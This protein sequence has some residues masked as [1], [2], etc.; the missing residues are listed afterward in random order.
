MLFV[1][2]YF[3]IAALFVESWVVFRRMRGKMH[4]YIF[5]SC[6]ATLV[7]N[8]GYL[9]QMR[10]V[11]EEAY[12]NALEVAYLGKVWIPYSL[13]LFAMAL[14]RIRV[15][16]PA[17]ITLSVVHVVTFFLLLT[18]EYHE[19][20]YKDI[21][22]V[23]TGLFPQLAHGSGPWHV[24]YDML[25]AFY[26][27][28][29]LIQMFR[30]WLREKDPT[31]KGCLFMVFL[32]FVSDSGSFLLYKLMKSWSYDVTTLGYTVAALFMYVAIFRYDLLDTVELAREFVIDELSEG[33]IAV[34]AQGTVG[35]YN[36]PA[37]A[38]FPS[39]ETD[40]QGVVETLRGAIERREPLRFGER[41]Y[42]PEENLLSR[43][44]G[45]AGTIYVLADNTEH[46]R[47][48]ER[49]EEQTRRADSAS[50]A[51]SAFLANM[52]HEIRTPINA[53]LGM[54]EMILRESA[55]P[56]ILTYAEDIRSAGKTLLS[57][58][59][60]VLDLSKI[61]EGRMEILPAPY[62]LGSLVND[63]INMTRPRAEDKGLRFAVKV[64]AAIPGRLVG[65]EVR[66]RQCALNVLTNA[67]K[68]T[69][70]GS[71]TMELGYERT[72]EDAVT[73]RFSVS[74]TGIG[75]K[76]ED[77]ERLFA[78]FAR[79]EELRNRNI[80]GAGLGMSITKQLLS[81]M[82]SRLEVESVYGAGSTFAFSVA[83]PVLAWEPIGD[84]EE[85]I[86]AVE[87]H[88]EYRTLFWAPEARILVVDDM[89]VNLHVIR[90]LL[91]E[92]RLQVDTALSG[93]E[94]LA[95]AAQRRYDTIFIDHMMPE[96]DGIETLRALRAMPDLE[97]VPCIVL[98]ANAIS[99]ARERYLADGFTD[100][101]SKPVNGRQLEE[102]LRRC[103][104]PEK[105]REPEPETEPEPEPPPVALPGWLRQV[106]GLDVE[107]GI[108]LCGTEETYLG[109]LT[110]YARD[111]D[112]AADEIERCRGAGDTDGVILRVHALK[113]TSRTVGAEEL[114]AL[115]ERLE[116][117]GKAGDT[118][119]LFGQLDGL[120]IR[121]RTLGEALAPLRA[122][123]AA[124]DAPRPTIP[125]ELLREAYRT[126]RECAEAFDTEGAEAML[127]RLEGFRMPEEERARVESLRRV[128]G[129]FDW[130]K[131]EGLLP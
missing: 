59:N 107:R 105:L 95:L 82:G 49:L 71:V 88:P 37:L 122:E 17:R 44:G 102:M 123:D 109:T 33:I 117:A 12:V 111:V 74:D 93:R 31:T 70:K 6:A 40:A 45:A 91:K 21:R 46:F 7:N 11:S 38:L 113:S 18:M 103:L 118:Q 125:D 98:T 76:P 68:Y 72:G 130:D 3:S 16:V 90:A 43:G 83:Q 100:Y 129:D 32:A 27:S 28:F 69:E 112:R 110:I 23:Q 60:D 61:E 35:Y 54:D 42:S 65:D 81:L 64:D 101:L 15:S 73:L 53:I 67:V 92:T 114:G 97:G 77:M 86:R 51:K 75:M 13:F 24:L 10:A 52:S 104:P 66:L 89:P 8:V 119:T 106:A 78:P 121:F 96:M 2:Q 25:L 55:Q 85:R 36:K 29:A 84:I 4:A 127:R 128:I 48:V 26:I 56:D 34:D 1:I 131:I 108:A 116:V 22:Y 94:A 99:G 120:L 57:I 20:Y 47:Y 5:L 62:D 87:P 124:E 126:L 79:I 58:I 50:K 39:L 41:V 115:A 30:A 19:L 14:C 63:L 80:E 9:M